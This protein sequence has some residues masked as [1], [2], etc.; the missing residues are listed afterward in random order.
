MTATS[1]FSADDADFQ[2]QAYPTAFGVTFTP[3]VQGIVLAVIG[4][5]LAGLVATQ[6]V[7][8]AYEEYQQLQQQVEDKRQAWEQKAETAR[9]VS[10]VVAGLKAAEA[11]NQDVR[12]LF[13]SQAALETLLLDLNELIVSSGAQL[14]KFNPEYTSS[15]ILTDNSLGEALNNKLKR[16]VTEVSFQGTFSQTTAILQA[17]DRSQTV[18]VLRDFTVEAL[19]EKAS[20]NNPNARRDAIK[21]TFKLFAYVPLSPEEVKAAEAAAAAAKA[22][23]EAQNQQQR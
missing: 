14:L 11:K 1:G 10:E 15:G 7:A 5:G 20:Q 13:S 6:V 23:E 8:P 19:G 9:R 16:Q 21:S 18:L 4:L 22:Q 17:I 12:T 2:E 3:T